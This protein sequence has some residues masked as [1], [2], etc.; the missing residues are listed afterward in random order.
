MFLFFCSNLRLNVEKSSIWCD[1]LL[2]IQAGRFFLWLV[3]LGKFSSMI[4][5]SHLY[6][7]VTN[8]STLL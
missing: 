1:V 2:D 3:T 8:S 6:H 7:C 4:L 5:Q